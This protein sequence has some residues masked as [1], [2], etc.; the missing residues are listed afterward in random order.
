MDDEDTT[1]DSDVEALME[2]LVYEEPF[3]VA[4]TTINGESVRNLTIQPCGCFTGEVQVSADTDDGSLLA[5]EVA[6]ICKTIP[7]RLNIRAILVETHSRLRGVQGA[8]KLPEQAIM[9]KIVDV[10]REIATHA[11][12][13]FTRRTGQPFLW[14]DEPEQPQDEEPM[15][16]FAVDPKGNVVF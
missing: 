14:Q 3:S 12:E 11:V 2:E 7:A 8:D 9:E 5:A 1:I 15:M 10:L 13:E 6:A 4:A 16:S